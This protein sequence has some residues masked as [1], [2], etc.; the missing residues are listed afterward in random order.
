M[1]KNFSSGMKTP[2]QVFK[3]PT[4]KQNL[5]QYPRSAIFY[6]NSFAGIVYH[7]HV[8]DSET[9]ASNNAYET[10][11]TALHGDV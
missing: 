6:M 4:N 9:I 11:W 10:V 8:W 1:S 7:I 3:K 5:H 2:K